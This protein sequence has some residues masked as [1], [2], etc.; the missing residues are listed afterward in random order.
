MQDQKPADTVSTWRAT[1][2]EGAGAEGVWATSPWEP[3]FLSSLFLTRSKGAGTE[4]VWGHLSIVA[5]VP[6][7]LVSDSFLV[8]NQTSVLKYR[9]YLNINQALDTF[10]R[11]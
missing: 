10:K 6:E 11:G 3:R 1:R 4:S 5:T 7:F 9:L 8:D 2:S